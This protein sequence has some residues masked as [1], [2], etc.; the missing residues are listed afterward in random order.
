MRLLL[1]KAYVFGSN[2]TIA[3]INGTDVKIAK[4]HSGLKVNSA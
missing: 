2:S 4:M 1:V 3:I